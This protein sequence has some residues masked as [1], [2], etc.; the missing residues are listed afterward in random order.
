MQ[1]VN[2]KWSAA[3]LVLVCKKCS[4]ERIPEETPEIAKKIGDFSL[5]D[6]LKKALK[7]RELWG[8]VRVVGTSCMDVCA[9]GKVT[10]CIDP[11]TPGAQ[12]ET[13]VVD[14]LDEREAVLERIVKRFSR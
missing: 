14:P 3:G 7:E 10:V 1:D 6:W 8:A 4:E 9:K 2:P 5:R 12:S 13:F 11:Q